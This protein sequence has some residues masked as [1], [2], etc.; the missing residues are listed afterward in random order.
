MIKATKVGTFGEFYFLD[1]NGIVNQSNSLPHEYLFRLCLWENLFLSGPRSMGL[2]DKGQIL[3]AQRFVAGVLPTQDE[4]DAFIEDSGFS[5]VKKSCWLWKME[6][7]EGFEIWLG[8]AR[9]D[10]FV[11]TEQSIVPIDIRMWFTPL[12]K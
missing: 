11:K 5:A 6:H 7:E 4:V 2:T 10:N 8:D 3:S 12:S 9:A 1:Q